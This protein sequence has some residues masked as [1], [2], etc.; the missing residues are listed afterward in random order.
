LIFWKIDIFKC[1]FFDSIDVIIR[2]G[3]LYSVLTI[4]ISLE[5]NWIGS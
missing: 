2:W 4:L 1:T 5:C 3:Y